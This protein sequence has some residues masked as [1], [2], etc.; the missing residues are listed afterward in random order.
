MFSYGLAS[1]PD[2]DAM[3][4]IFVARCRTDPDA[5]RL[6]RITKSR[7]V[8]EICNKKSIS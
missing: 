7:K 6:V 4:S 8:L 2:G 3:I 5:G 1:H